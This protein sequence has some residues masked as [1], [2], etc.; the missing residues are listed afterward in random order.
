MGKSSSS[1]A[2]NN[3]E[4]VFNN[5][6]YGGSA[7]GGGGGFAKNLNLADSTMGNISTSSN[8]YISQSD[9]GAISA[10]ADI[11]LAG[12]ETNADTMESLLGAASGLVELGFESS[13]NFADK[14]A[15][16]VEGSMSFAENLVGDSFNMVAGAA[17]IVNESAERVGDAWVDTNK[18]IL[19]MSNNA[20]D[21]T[22]RA[23][24]NAQYSID[25]SNDNALNSI[26]AVV[27]GASNS[28]DDTNA[29]ALK[30]VSEAQKT[31][32]ERTTD[33]LL[34]WGLGG[35][36]LVTMAMS[37]RGKS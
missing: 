9:S 26:L 5:V 33:T 1:Q 31:E 2:T 15:D 24:E 17:E 8:T 25:R 34:K 4:T 6:D 7:D 23:Y 16:L 30:Y 20:L 28:V 11:A 21:T 14:N 36:T 22:T 35:M 13:T 10:G 19:A 37:M 27:A 32:S 29:D 18:S 12:I 3:K